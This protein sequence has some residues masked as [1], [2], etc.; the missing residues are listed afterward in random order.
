MYDN[1][2]KLQV[3]IAFKHGNCIDTIIYSC[4]YKRKLGL[5]IPYNTLYLSDG[6]IK[7]YVE[8]NVSYIELIKAACQ[9]T[10]KKR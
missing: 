7:K 5:T 2:R 9:E 8:N 4:L 10:C 6:A 3:A 1:N